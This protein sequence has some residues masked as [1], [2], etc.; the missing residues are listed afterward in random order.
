MLTQRATRL[1]TFYLQ[2]HSPKPEGKK[3]KSVHKHA[4]AFQPLLL[5][6]TWTICGCHSKECPC[7]SRECPGI[8]FEGMSL[9][10]KWLTS[11]PW[12]IRKGH[13]QHRGSNQDETKTN[14][15]LCPKTSSLNVY[16]DRHPTCGG[17]LCE[18]PNILYEEL[19]R[20]CQRCSLC[21]KQAT[22]SAVLD[23]N[24][25]W[26]LLQGMTLLKQRVS[27]WGV[28]SACL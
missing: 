25:L 7:G 2:T 28:S 16:M 13:N 21:S 15:N 8:P 5:F 12:H 27:T 4:F 14:Y 24:H 26:L 11:L 10:V 18:K 23:L 17:L 6:L 9:I 19:S 1:R 20:Q 3:A 22:S